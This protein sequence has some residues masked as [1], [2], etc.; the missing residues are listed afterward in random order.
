VGPS[1]DK[2]GRVDVGVGEAER[3]DDAVATPFGRPEVDEQDL[4]FVVV[5][6]GGQL[7][8]AA[9]EVAGGEL[10]LENGVL[11]V[12][13]EGAHGL[14]N[15]AEAFVVADVVADEIG[16]SH[17]I[18]LAEKWTDWFGQVAAGCAQVEALLAPCWT[19]F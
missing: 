12:V 1:D 5:D 9:D 3:G 7:G 8:A 6:D 11:E 15:L 18:T 16:L 4:V 17:F 14:E 2:T 10:A 19:Y 13:S